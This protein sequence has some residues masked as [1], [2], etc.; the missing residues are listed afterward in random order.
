MP[1][2]AEPRLHRL[3]QL[4]ARNGRVLLRMTSRSNWATDSRTFRGILGWSDE[5]GVGWRQFAPGKPQQNG[6]DE[7]SNGRPR[8][9]LPNETLF[10]SRPHARVVLETWRRDSNEARPPSKLGWL[11][12]RDYATA[13]SGNAGPARYEP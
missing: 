3:E 12:P 13:I 9:V 11:T 4:G 1:V 7:R 8:D 2:L 10:R 5:T 6:H